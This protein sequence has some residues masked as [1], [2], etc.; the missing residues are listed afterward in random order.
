M[1]TNNLMKHNTYGT[2]A[3]APASASPPCRYFPGAVGRRNV[4]AGAIPLPARQFLSERDHVLCAVRRLLGQ[5]LALVSGSP[6]IGRQPTARASASTPRRSRWPGSR[7]RQRDHNAAPTASPGG[8][9]TG[10]PGTP[11]SFNGSGSRDSD[12]S[13]ASYRWDWGDGTTPVFGAT[14][15]H[16][17]ARA[18]ASTVRLTVTDNAGA[19]G[20]ATTTA[21]IQ[22]P[23]EQ[24]GTSC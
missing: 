5:Q 10:R 12:G 23:H 20:T 8:P 6:Y 15:S 14:P 16:T 21:T 17:Y 9:Y 1:F 7:P 13:I 4:L 24:C 19:T 2:S 3:R 22:A 11:I 18:G